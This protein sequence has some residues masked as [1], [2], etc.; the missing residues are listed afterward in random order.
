M[1]E[2]AMLKRSRGMPAGAHEPG[3]RAG[4][5]RSNGLVLAACGRRDAAAHR[6]CDGRA[7]RLRLAPHLLKCPA[8]HLREDQIFWTLHNGMGPRNTSNTCVDLRERRSRRCLS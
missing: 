2:P 1:T 8:E 3:G 4:R 6:D 7:H 5:G